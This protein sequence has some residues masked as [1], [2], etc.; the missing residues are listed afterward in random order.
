MKIIIPE[1]RNCCHIYCYNDVLCVGGFEERQGFSKTPG[2]GF[3]DL[4]GFLFVC[5]EESRVRN[6]VLCGGVGGLD[7]R[8][9]F[10]FLKIIMVSRSRN[11]LT[12]FFFFF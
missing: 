12:F 2:W 8:R 6:S 9:V 10:S 4:G 11:K 7:K 3:S 5:Q 1:V